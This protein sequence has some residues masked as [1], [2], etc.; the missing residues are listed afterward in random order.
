MARLQLWLGLGVRLREIV[1]VHGRV[2]WR[3]S[4]ALHQARAGGAGGS[5]LH[6]QDP[7]YSSARGSVFI[8]IGLQKG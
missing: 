2:H 5:L 3:R 1:D 7:G 6:G 4:A 8:T